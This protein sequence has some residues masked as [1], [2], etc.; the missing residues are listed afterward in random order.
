MLEGLAR[1]N[2]DV[3]AVRVCVQT[4]SGAAQMAEIGVDAEDAQENQAYFGSHDVSLESHLDYI[5]SKRMQRGAERSR[6]TD[7]S[8]PVF[9]TAIEE[10]TALAERAHWMSPAHRITFQLVNVDF[11]GA[12]KDLRS[13]D[14]MPSH[15]TGEAAVGAYQ[16]C[17]YITVDAV[18]ERLDAF[19]TPSAR[20]GG[21]CCFPILTRR[22]VQALRPR[23]LVQFEYDEAD[24][25]WSFDRA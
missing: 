5:F 12:V 24:E 25:K 6:F 18:A 22:S 2:E 23:G 14:P 3:V 4:K 1:S 7:G 9:Y 20:R 13:I 21:G 11:H 15:L 19:K 8:I 17:F 10:E 16:S